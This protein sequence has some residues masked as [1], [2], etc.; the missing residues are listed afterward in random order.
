MSIIIFIII[1]AIL[2]F[3]HELGHF[4]FAKLSGIR[5]DEFALGFPPRLYSKKIG[6][7]NYSVNL[8]P[9]GGYVQIHGENPNEDSISGPDKERSFINK[10]KYIQA[11]VL[12]AGILFNI[13]FA[14]ILISISLTSGLPAAVSADLNPKYLQNVH[15]I[16]TGVLPNSPAET[17]GIQKGDSLIGQNRTTDVQKAIR[18]SNGAPVQVKVL[19]G[20]EEKTFVITPIRTNADSPYMI[21]IA[22]GE[23][24]VFKVPLYLAPWEGLKLTL[25][26]IKEVSL[27]LIHFLGNILTGHAD[28]SQVTGPVGIVGLV[29]QASSFGFVYLLGFTALISL[30]LAIINVVPFPA[31]DGGRL[32]FVLIEAVKGSPIKPKIANTLN[33]VGFALLILLMLVVTYK[34]IFKLLGK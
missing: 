1:L 8:I 33:A 16:I 30:N 19:R 15:V 11:V 7:T 18:E 32:L 34:D 17:A 26:S 29:G 12:F 14:W 22:M 20:S 28:F 10:P 21:G 3:V 6:E 31:L 23:I 2:I 27:G 13:I 24:G 4:L 5:V 9:F 25:F